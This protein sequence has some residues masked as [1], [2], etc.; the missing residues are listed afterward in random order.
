MSI[1]KQIKE[2]ITLHKTHLSELKEVLEEH[3][4]NKSKVYQIKDFF[5]RYD[6]EQEWY[7]KKGN[8]NR[9]IEKTEQE[10]GELNG[11]LTQELEIAWMN[12][13]VQQIFLC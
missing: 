10:L 7:N 3:I 12:G 1:I 11:L 9:E 8:L 2:Q 6:K 13:R 5:I 4:K